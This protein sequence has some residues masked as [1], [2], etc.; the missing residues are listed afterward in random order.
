MSEEN[1]I[2]RKLTVVSERYHNFCEHYMYKTLAE[3]EFLVVDNNYPFTGRPLPSN[4]KIV[5]WPDINWDEVDL[6][7]AVTVNRWRDVLSHGKPC[8]FHIDQVPQDWD[9]PDELAK[10]LGDNP[11]VYWSDEEAEMWKCGTPII[12]PHPIDTEIFKGYDPLK[13]TAITIA[14]RAF[15]GWG[16]DLKG[17]KVLEPAYKLIPI[18]VIAKDDKN[19]PNA[20]SI[21]SEEEMVK[22]LQLYQVYFNCAWK[23]DRSPLE[24]MGCGMPVVALKTNFNVYKKYFNE[25][26][27]NIIYAENTLAMINETNK[28]LKDKLR[29]FV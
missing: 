9:K 29:C 3:H 26:N 8:V 27:G 28:L 11:V 6:G 20:I 12:R 17:Y 7:Y 2:K 19:F 14:T 25:E 5:P 13:A 15:S 24:A 10:I 18:Q 16:P 22:A 23:L 1:Q 21:E 4:A